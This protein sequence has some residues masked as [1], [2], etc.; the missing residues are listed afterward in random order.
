MVITFFSNY[1][2]HHQ[3]PLCREFL[4]MD[5]VEFNFVATTPISKKRLE[6]GYA[7]MNAEPFVIRAYETEG[8]KEALRLARESDIIIHGNSR[9]DY[10]KETINSGKPFFRYYERLFKNYK[11]YKLGYVAFNHW[12]RHGGSKNRKAHMLCAS[13]FT[14]IDVARIGA[15]KGRCYRWGY[16][17]EVREYED[18]ERLVD[19]KKKATLLWAGRMIDWKHPEDPISVAERLKAEGYDFTL[20]MIGTGNMEEQLRELVNSKNLNDRVNILGSM[21]PEKV[22][23][24]MENSQV[25]LFTSDKQEGWGAVLNESMNSGCAVVASHAIG[26]VPFLLQDKENG[27]IYR[28][29]DVDDLYSKVK[30]LLDNPEDA[31]RMGIAA[32]NTLTEQWNAKNAAERFIKLAEAVLSGEDTPDLFPDGVCSKAPILKNN[33]Y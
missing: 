1:L 5:D 23:E 27:L 16:F 4:A 32:Y 3:L 33:W 30:Y 10:E 26:S 31:R 15:Y 8:H 18:I 12:K 22:R 13:A 25:F 7:D 9:L 6:M 14:A 11:F 21:P 28:S 29:E 2:N 20:N 17:P 24:Y 19:G